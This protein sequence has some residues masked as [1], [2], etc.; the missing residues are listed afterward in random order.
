MRLFIASP[1]R[2][3]NYDEIRERF[4]PL[5]EGKWVMRE[6]LHL[7]WVFLGERPESELSQIMARLQ[8][9][10]GLRD[11]VKLRGLGSFGR[12]AKIL[13]AS[14]KE[15]SLYK[16]A[17]QLRAAGFENHRF[18]PHVTLCRIKKVIKKEEFFEVLHAF[19]GVE[20]GEIESA[21][22]LYR[23][24]LREEGAHYRILA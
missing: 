20:I 22:H 24:I 12:P 2:I 13:Y 10:E 19:E 1:V 9:V 16:K 23:S 3:I 5:I 21:I 17:S 11:S 15:R 8:E 6:N 4:A 18:H 14:A 7:T